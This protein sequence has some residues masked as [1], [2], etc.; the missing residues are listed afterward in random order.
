MRAPAAILLGSVLAAAPALAQDPPTR[1]GPI[2]APE[3]DVRAETTIEGV[4]EDFHESKQ[5][6]DHPG[7]HLLVRTDNEAVEVHACPVRFLSDLEFVLERG[8]RVTI[9]GS[10]PGS[11]EILVA[12]EI[13]MG[14]I[15]M[16]LRDKTGAP[17]W[18]EP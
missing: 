13:A 12:R 10:R 2:G 4:V 6:G 15:T 1:E 8:D 18:P 11:G 3:Y 5:V 9:T 7:L 16:G 14:E 17:V